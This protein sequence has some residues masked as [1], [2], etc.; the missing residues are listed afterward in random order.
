VN[1]VNF[2]QSIYIDYNG[3]ASLTKNWFL[4]LKAVA[5]A[6]LYEVAFI[7]HMLARITRPVAH[8][9][10]SVGWLCK[11]LADLMKITQYRDRSKM[12]QDQFQA[13][14]CRCESFITIPNR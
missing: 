5:V 9:I 7:I 11:A 13:F 8:R 4:V 3:N 10:A 12:D 14:V 2:K 6:C 1:K